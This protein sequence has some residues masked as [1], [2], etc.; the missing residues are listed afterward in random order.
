VS[1]AQDIV[2]DLAGDNDRDIR[3]YRDL[4]GGLSFA[5]LDDVTIPVESDSRLALI[6]SVIDGNS[7]PADS[8]LW[9]D[10]ESYEGSLNHLTRSVIERV[11]RR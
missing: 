7:W 8:T 3:V 2:R 10:V 9:V 11:T 6:K 5:T 4:D 1:E